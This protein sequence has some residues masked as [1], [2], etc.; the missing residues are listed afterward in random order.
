MKSRRKTTRH[1]KGKG[2]NK[3]ILKIMKQGEQGGGDEGINFFYDDVH[4]FSLE[5]QANF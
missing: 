3:C 1:G 4:D 2:I 5:Q